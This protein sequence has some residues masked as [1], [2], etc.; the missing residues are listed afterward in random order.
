MSSVIEIEDKKKSFGQ[1][2][3]ASMISFGSVI[4]VGVAAAVTLLGW[5][6]F[7]YFLRGSS[8][9]A[10]EGPSPKKGL[11][12]SLEESSELA[13]RSESQVLSPTHRRIERV[14]KES[15]KM[16]GE[17]PFTAPSFKSEQLD[18]SDEDFIDLDLKAPQRHLL[19]VSESIPDQVIQE[20]QLWSFDLS[21]YF[22][23]RSLLVG[24]SPSW[25]SLQYQQLAALPTGGPAY[26]VKFQGGKAFTAEG[27]GWG[28]Y[29]ILSF[30]QLNFTSVPGVTTYNIGISSDGSLVAVA[31]DTMVPIY[32]L[33][34]SRPQL[35]GSY[36]PNPGSSARDL[37]FSDDKSVMYV[38]SGSGGVDLVS[39]GSSPARLSNY[40]VGGGYAMSLAR[41]GSDLYVA[42][43]ST[44][45]TRLTINGTALQF[46]SSLG[47]G[48]GKG[49]SVSFSSPHVLF[50]NQIGGLEVIDPTSP[51]MQVVASVP[52]VG[53]TTT[54]AA[55]KGR[56]AFSA[57]NSAGVPITDLSSLSSPQRLGS[58]AGS[59]TTWSV[60]L[61]ENG[62]VWVAQDV[63]GIKVYDPS[64]G[65]FVGQAPT[66]IGK[67]DS[68]SVGA[69]DFNSGLLAEESF[70]VILDDLPGLG[71]ATIPARTLYPNP[72]DFS[73]IPI[74]IPLDTRTLFSSSDFL[75][76]SLQKAGGQAAPSWMRLGLVP[77]PISSLT[78]SS[79]GVSSL[80]VC[81]QKAVVI[82]NLAAQVIDI[83]DPSQ[84]QVLRNIS[85]Q[86][87]ISG[88]PAIDPT[89]SIAYLG[90][91]FV[92]AVDL[93]SGLQIAQSTG[94]G[95][96]YGVALMES[97]IVLVPNSPFGL[98]IYNSS[99][100]LLTSVPN[101]AT[102]V[103]VVGSTAFVGTESASG[104]SLQALNMINPALPVP[105]WSVPTTQ[106]NTYLIASV[107]RKRLFALTANRLNVY[108]FNGVLKGSAPISAAAGSPTVLSLKGD[109][110][111]VAAAGS[112]TLLFDVS[113]DVPEQ[114]GVI[115]SGTELSLAVGFSGK[116]AFSGRSSG[117]VQASDISQASLTVSPPSGNGG[118]SD[119]AL[120]VKASDSLGASVSTSTSLSIW[121]RPEQ[122]GS[123]PIQQLFAGQSALFFPPAGLIKHPNPSARLTF[124][125]KSSS[126]SE[127]SF[128]PLSATFSGIPRD[129]SVGPFTIE[130]EV[131]DGIT[132]P[133][134]VNITGQV[135]F[136]PQL[137]QPIP[138]QVAGVGV[139]CNLTL[140]TS[141]TFDNFG[142]GSLTYSAQGLPS[143]LSMDPLTG[144]VSG[145][146]V[147]AETR[148][149]VITA[150]SS[151]TGGQVST[152]CSFVV[153]V[154]PQLGVTPLNNMLAAAAQSTILP[155]SPTVFT[156]T[157]GALVP[158]LTQASGAPLPPGFNFDP[159]TWTL[160]VDSSA[161]IG[162]SNL[163]LTGTDP[164]GAKVSRTF[165]IEVREF[166]RVLAPIVA[167]PTVVI[168]QPFTYQVP[169]GTFSGSG[170][171]SLN[172]P[173]AG[174]SIDPVSGLISGSASSLGGLNLDLVFTDAQG[175]SV[176]TPITFNVQTVLDPAVPTVSAQQASV[177]APYEDVVPNFSGKNG[178]PVERYTEQHP[179]SE[180]WLSAEQVSGGLLLK[181]IPYRR[182]SDG[183]F[184]RL[185][186]VTITGTDCYNASSSISIPFSVDGT[187]YWS[188]ILR[189]VSIAAPITLAGLVAIIKLSNAWRRTKY[190]VEIEFTEGEIASL[191]LPADFR[192]NKEIRI[193]IEEEQ[194]YCC[195]KGKKHKHLDGDERLPPGM[196]YNGIGNLLC[197]D[198]RSKQAMRGAMEAKEAKQDERDVLECMVMTNKSWHFPVLG[199]FTKHLIISQHRVRIQDSAQR[200]VT[201]P[202]AVGGEESGIEMVAHS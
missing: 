103:T 171:Y 138:N 71:S 47:A 127:L 16:M 110:I 65:S 114:I 62:H 147:T 36:L 128:N 105:L 108:D 31:A 66:G 165:S 95:A 177:G 190:G 92:R 149:L 50:S 182:L 163:L 130:L 194:D 176:R 158:Q 59:G 183:S 20:G 186:T 124:S 75:L 25:A 129:S 121:G 112:G 23:N 49:R 154:L 184:P 170:R 56:I 96:N 156:S 125:V 196:S 137:S 51:A 132:A 178:C 181:G 145:I 115:S 79:G 60:V 24:S 27:N 19:S 42:T 195:F 179:S 143:G 148:N 73:Y 192:K 17:T 83:S 167:S 45:I 172:N 134:T 2:Q 166:P 22:G 64:K 188:D 157:T 164:A 135:S 48:S 70:E 109:L 78:P 81:G 117:K 102:F 34:G 139:P 58:L 55:K 37:E 46:V 14:L 159:L 175:G 9:R 13:L 18:L 33:Q 80:K 120:E 197:Y 180:D 93:S 89:C 155:I 86:S 7:N 21:P 99:L 193:K 63:A 39:V 122:N 185:F 94:S 84:M 41:S 142:Q 100:D 162:S 174:I 91:R 152:T 200:E 191:P 202:S 57:E 131:S 199:Y 87:S 201:S 169:T 43:F 150:T 198:G 98:Q 77:S 76:L 161:V 187:A 140:V 97:G 28:I 29:D 44:G 173:P 168:D 5:A 153:E 160:T 67:Q 54:G 111:G 88:D 151:V 35:L 189:G 6:G 69:W 15:E 118:A 133:I 4:K 30:A 82:N 12:D 72:L 146:A 53:G 90:D 136:L 8:A 116:T 3:E 101:N 26:S 85:A 106:R 104:Y 32:T 52:T 74:S 107:K 123:F 38:A 1:G 144:V 113:T 68:F 61:D 11:G 141:S 10:I 126:L 40:P 119:Y